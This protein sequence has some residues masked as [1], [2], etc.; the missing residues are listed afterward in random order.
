MSW[1][2]PD[3]AEKMILDGINRAAA[4]GDDVA[5]HYVAGQSLGSKKRK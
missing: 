2:G 4:A 5:A 1:V 3:R